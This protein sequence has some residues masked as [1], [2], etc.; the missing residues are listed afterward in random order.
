[1]DQQSHQNRPT[2]GEPVGVV[3]GSFFP[4]L[5]EL[6]RH[7]QRML[8]LWNWKSAWLSLALRGP[9]FL[10]AGLQ[11]GLIATLSAVLTES[12][13]CM[14]TAGFY[15]AIAQRLRNAKP[16]W[17]TAVFL[18]GVVPAVF[19]VVEFLLHRLRGT[20]HLRV[21]E[22]ISI[23]ISGVSSLFNWYAMRR[24]A[25]LVGKEGGSFVSDLRRLPGLLISFIIALPSWIKDR[26][27]R[28]ASH[29]GPSS[30]H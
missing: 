6:L 30:E 7:P 14:S 26:R 22:I 10:A 29:Q 1:L 8:V 24:G 27:R 21:A 9:I 23:F 5:L 17:L 19:Q 20:P 16:E 13:V 11:R 2:A 25:L 4:E 28:Q 12:V 15:G 18:A 3:G